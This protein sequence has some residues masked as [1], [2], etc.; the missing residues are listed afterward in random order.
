ME[1]TTL[2]VRTA[3]GHDLKVGCYRGDGTGPSILILH[4][5]LSHMGWYRRLGEALAARGSAVFLLDRRGAGLSGGLAGH[6]DSWRTVVDDISRV[7]A[8]IRSLHP[9]ANVCALGISL[10]AAMTIAASLVR[11][12]SFHRQAALSPGL[13][14]ALSLSLPRRVGVAYSAFARPRVLYELPYTVEQLCEAPEL[15]SSLWNDPLRTRAVTARFLLEVFRMQRFVR[16]EIVHLHVPLLALLAEKDAL[17]DNEVVLRVLHR[18]AGSPVRVELFQ[19]AAHVLPATVPLEELVGRIWH[20]FTA[21]EVAL[22]NRV[23]IQQVPPFHVG[24][25][26]A[27]A[28]VPAVQAS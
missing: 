13:A 18:V 16:R 21:A 27:A 14:P 5:L 17:V 2:D 25:A 28:T 1:F 23:V 19:G 3:D 20:W 9:S 8:L 15:G 11:R 7:I 26:G 6:M 4:G 10:G 12:D 24:H 22:D